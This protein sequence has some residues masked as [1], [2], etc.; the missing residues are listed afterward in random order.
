MAIGYPVGATIGGVIAIQ[1]IQDHGWPSVF[2]FGGALS[3]LMIPV[4]VW[5]LPE[6]LDFLLVKRPKNALPRVN[7][8][9]AR[10]G[11]PALAVLPE[12]NDEKEA[13]SRSFLSLF[14]GALLWRTAIICTAYFLVMLSFYFVLNWT[15]KVLVDQG[16]SLGAGISGAIFLNVGGIF[17]GLILGWY[18]RKF[19]LL[20][21]A[22]LYMFLIFVSMAAFGYVENNL[23]LMLTIAVIMGFFMIGSIISLYAIIGASYPVRIRNTGT[24]LALGI[25]RLGAIAGPYM[26]GVLIAGGWEKWE[27]CLALGIPAALAG[28][29]ILFLPLKGAALPEVK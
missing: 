15:P 19:G 14:D 1:L 10:M 18:T 5:L 6:S 7:A 11:R 9:L 27:Y 2:L 25:G 12:I 4:V 13:G 3:I 26:G 29:V 17:G 22:G 8:V 24:G 23:V 28:L 16:L 21:L 20:R